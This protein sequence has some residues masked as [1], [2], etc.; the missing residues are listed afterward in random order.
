M[1]ALKIKRGSEH[2]FGRFVFATG[3]FFSSPPSP[4]TVAHFMTAV[5]VS[6]GFDGQGWTVYE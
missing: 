5:A 1:T 3:G 6:C 4:L 2:G